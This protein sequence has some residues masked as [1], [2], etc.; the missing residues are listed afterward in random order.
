MDRV[1]W[2]LSGANAQLV[3]LNELPV[4]GSWELLH[5]TSQDADDLQWVRLSSMHHLARVAR[6]SGLFVVARPVA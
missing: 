4:D 3:V 6:G 1:W 2:F 5:G